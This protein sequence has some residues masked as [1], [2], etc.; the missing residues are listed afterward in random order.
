MIKLEDALLK[1]SYA[2]GQTLEETIGIHVESFFSTEKQNV[3]KI[4]QYFLKQ[5]PSQDLER[6]LNTCAIFKTKHHMILKVKGA[7]KT[8]LFIFPISSFLSS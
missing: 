6:V 4:T 2:P 5:I 1:N 7:E 3:E 8:P